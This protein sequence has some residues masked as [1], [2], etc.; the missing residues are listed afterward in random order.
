MRMK[1]HMIPNIIRLSQRAKNAH[2][3][4]TRLLKC[5]DMC[6][7]PALCAEVILPAQRSVH[8]DPGEHGPA[9]GRRRPA[10]LAL[11]ITHDAATDMRSP[12]HDPGNAIAFS[13]I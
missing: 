12:I 7:N 6:Y 2:C 4:A 11:Q 8:T 13:R 10:W 3:A 9:G 1:Q 5:P